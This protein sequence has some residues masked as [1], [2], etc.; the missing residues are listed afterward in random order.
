M[1]WLSGSC[2]FLI[3]S[4]NQKKASC[5]S[6]VSNLAENGEKMVKMYKTDVNPVDNKNIF[7][8]RR[9][10]MFVQY[11]II[12]GLITVIERSESLISGST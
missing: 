3:L 12:P 4:K 6:C 9:V 8:A 5:S 1:A 10:L 11:I 2:L 7:I